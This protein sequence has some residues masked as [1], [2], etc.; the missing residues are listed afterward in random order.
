M[1]TNI[2]T[3]AVL[4]NC[5]LITAQ[6]EFDA[7]KLVQ[8][9]INGTAR[10][11]SMAGAFGA[12]GGD[13]S[14]IK[15]NPAGLGIYRTS[16]ITGTLNGLTQNS[17]SNWKYLNNGALNNSYGYDN[18]YKIGFNNFSYVKASPTFRSENSSDGLLSSNWS[19]SYNRLKSFNRNSTI[20]SGQS[21]SSITDY[22]AYFTGNIKSSDLSSSNDPYNNTSIPWISELAYQGYLIDTV[23]GMS[24][25]SSILGLSEKVLPSYTIRETGYVDEYSL[26]WAGNISNMLYLGATI[27]LQ[28]I[29]YT[30]STQYSEVLVKVA[31]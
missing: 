13:A 5:T 6:T 20:K 22:M 30:A 17:T 3:L 10:Y 26:G 7:Q 12:L 23:A 11:M 31:A 25:W 21:S 18:L 24:S 19:F 14:A 8:T 9:D 1:K 4:L 2:L 27:N 29:D 15:D 28:S 16:E